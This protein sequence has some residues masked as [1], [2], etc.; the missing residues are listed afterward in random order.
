MGQHGC[1]ENDPNGPVFDP[2]HGVFHHFYQIVRSSNTA[3]LRATPRLLA[4]RCDLEVPVSCSG[5]HT[6]RTPLKDTLRIL[7]TE[8]SV[9]LRVFYDATFAEAFFQQGRV[10]MTFFFFRMQRERK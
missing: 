10:A 2:V 1:A 6:T 5:R 4:R 7:S 9:E 8:T 3:A